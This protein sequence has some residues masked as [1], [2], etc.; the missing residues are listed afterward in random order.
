ML[1]LACLVSIA[2]PVVFA[3]NIVAIMVC[4]HDLYE[5]AK[6]RQHKHQK[7]KRRRTT[8][9]AASLAALVGFMFLGIWLLKAVLIPKLQAMPIINRAMCLTVLVITIFVLLGVSAIAIQSAR[10]EKYNNT[11]FRK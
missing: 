7:A 1:A 10:D 11:N 8:K 6:R 3:V 2:V 5:T 9:L 4:I